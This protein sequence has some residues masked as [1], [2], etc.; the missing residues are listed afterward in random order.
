LALVAASTSGVVLIEL[1][2]VLVLLGVLG[3]MAGRVGLPAIPLFLIAGLMLGEG[4]LVPLDASE[5]FVRIGADLG[6]V[7]LLLLLGLEY[8]P[9]D[10]QRG[11]RTN[12][13]AGVLDLV[14]S[15]IPGLLL[16]LLL[17]WGFL[18]SLVLAGITYIS[19][20][21]IIAHQLATLD[22]IGNRE[23]PVILTILVIE[24]LVMAAFLPLI[25]V[26][27]L[28]LSPLQGGLSI[29]AALAMVV[30]VLMVASRFSRPISR[31]LD[32]PSQEVLLLTIL[33]LTLLI[34]GLAEQIRISAAVVAFLIGLTLSGSV[35][36]RG[37][38]LLLPIRDVFGG[39]FFV[40][41]GLQ[42]DPATL[43]PV[44]VPALGLAVVTALTKVGTGWWA[45]SQA[46]VGRRGRQ[47][48]ALSLIPRGEFSIVLAGLAVAAGLES[49]L[50]ALAAC[51]VMLLAIAGSLAMR[52]ADELPIYGSV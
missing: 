10:L 34:G 44:L 37:R 31:I 21:G 13:R 24:D 28:G 4:G 14:S 48:A 32:S 35:A 39:L 49:E 8:T 23:T 1:G 22:R 11:L 46:G 47:R 38:E 26:L 3:R 7:I 16:G 30:V 5:D 27:I 52:Y 19:S 40:F 51:Y 17:G 18:A 43:P 36:E 29:A 12:W 45:A 6:V 2:A 20:S 15:S 25:G 33:G 41:F 50:G 42:V 9:A